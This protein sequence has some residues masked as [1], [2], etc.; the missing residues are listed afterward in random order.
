MSTIGRSAPP[1]LILP[2]S[3]KMHD[4]AVLMEPDSICLKLKSSSP[5][6]VSYEFVAH[7]IYYDLSDIVKPAQ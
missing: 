1:M 5:T 3:E 7:F 2:E 6:H 4:R